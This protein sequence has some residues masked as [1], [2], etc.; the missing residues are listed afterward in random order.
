MVHR[1]CFQEKED[2]WP[3][4][5]MCFVAIGPLERAKRMS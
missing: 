5:E 4:T 1:F 3:S 2:H